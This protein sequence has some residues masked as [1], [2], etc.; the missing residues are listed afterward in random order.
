MVRGSGRARHRSNRRG[1]LHGLGRGLL[2]ALLLVGQAGLFS[3]RGIGGLLLFLVGGVA[4]DAQRSRLRLTV[5]D[6]AGRLARA[7]DCASPLVLAA[8]GG[9]AR[10]LKRVFVVGAVGSSGFAGCSAFEAVSGS[11]PAFSVL[12]LL[13]AEGSVARGACP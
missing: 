3:R 7:A 4:G 2:R 10:R 1:L 13:A 6:L 9:F 11:A 12:A 8:R 5:G